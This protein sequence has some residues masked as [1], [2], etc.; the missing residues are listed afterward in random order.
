[1]SFEEALNARLNLIQ[2]SYQMIE[3]CLEAHPPKLT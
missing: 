1:M 3:A 2:P